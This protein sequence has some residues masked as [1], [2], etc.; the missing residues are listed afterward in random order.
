MNLEPKLVKWAKEITEI[1]LWLTLFSYVVKIFTLYLPFLQLVTNSEIDA[2][3]SL[4]SLIA[5]QLIG[6]IH[7]LQKLFILLL[8][9]NTQLMKLNL[10]FLTTWIP[11]AT[12]QLASISLSL[13]PLI[14]TSRSLDVRTTQPPRPIL[15]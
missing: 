7:G 13:K 14:V 10:V 2:A 5:V 1:L 4:L 6:T 8:T 11:S 3:N 9:D 12:C 15:T